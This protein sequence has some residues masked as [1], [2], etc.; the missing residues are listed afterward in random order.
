[1]KELPDTVVPEK[2]FEYDDISLSIL[3]E[4]RKRI[5]SNTVL[6]IEICIRAKQVDEYVDMLKGQG[7]VESSYFGEGRYNISPT[8]KGEVLIQKAFRLRL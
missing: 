7:M 3:E 5:I 8:Q 6:G 2:E 1:M 4:L